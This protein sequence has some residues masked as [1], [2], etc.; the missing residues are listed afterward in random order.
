MYNNKKILLRRLR[1][2]QDVILYVSA[3]FLACIYLYNKLPKSSSWALSP[4]TWQEKT[5]N[6]N[7]VV[8]FAE[9]VQNGIGS[10]AEGIFGVSL[11]N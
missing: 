1:L 2:L 7:F 5:Y 10:K 9:F 4:I 8:N 11:L 3:L 6:A